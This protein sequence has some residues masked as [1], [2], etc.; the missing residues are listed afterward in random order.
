[1]TQIIVPIDFEAEAS[2][3]LRGF[4]IA[5][6]PTPDPDDLGAELP[7]CVC[8]QTGGTRENIVMDAA[9]LD[10]D[11]YAATEGAALDAARE[12]AA[13]VASLPINGSRVQ[14]RTADVTALPYA[15]PDPM[16]PTIPR[17]TFGATLRARAEVRET[18]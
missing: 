17:A 11:V 9:S 8:V 1:M 13:I 5:S 4:G 3:E 10:F 6:T 12:C 15:N 7:I 16:H 14:W 18:Q 2:A